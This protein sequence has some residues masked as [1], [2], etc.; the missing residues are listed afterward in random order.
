MAE[1]FKRLYAMVPI[2]IWVQQPS[3]VPPLSEAEMEALLN[4]TENSGLRDNS[5]AQTASSFEDL[6]G[7]M[8]DEEI[9]DVGADQV[10]QGFVGHGL[11]A[12][13]ALYE[14]KSL[15]TVLR[16]FTI[17]EISRMFPKTQFI[18]LNNLKEGESL[19][20]FRRASVTIKAVNDDK[21]YSLYGKL[22]TTTFLISCCAAIPEISSFLAQNSFKI[23]PDKC[24]YKI[25]P[26]SVKLLSRKIAQSSIC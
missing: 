7:E 9:P 2:Q 13:T 17:G 1:K 3:P 4:D 20:S 19:G 21:V 5:F 16:L 6:G 14:D 24:I 22:H 11:L 8:G 26:D 12:Q 18:N 10:V 25:V 23:G 15:R